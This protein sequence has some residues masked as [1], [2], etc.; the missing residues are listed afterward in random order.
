MF[1][2]FFSIGFIFLSS[3]RFTG[4]Q[5]LRKLPVVNFFFPSNHYSFCYSRTASIV[6]FLNLNMTYMS[7]VN[8]GICQRRKRQWPFLLLCTSFWTL[9][10]QTTLANTSHHI[11][12]LSSILRMPGRL[13]WTFLG[14]FWAQRF[15][16]CL[17]T[18]GSCHGHE[19]WAYLHLPLI[20]RLLFLGLRVLLDSLCVSK[21]NSHSFIRSYFF[22]L[23][24]DLSLGYSS[25]VIYFLLWMDYSLRCINMLLF[26]VS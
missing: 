19:M 18:N 22:H 12:Q 4:F 10:F 26:L 3:L 2:V 13:C 23:P 25:P 16:K 24:N 17:E 1:S 6:V 7:L 14:K 9:G 5:V 15:E 20:S 21:G 11:W 8:N